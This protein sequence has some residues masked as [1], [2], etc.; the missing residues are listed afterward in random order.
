MNCESSIKKAQP[1]NSNELCGCA[2]NLQ[3]V[4]GKRTTTQW[5]VSSVGRFILPDKATC[6][7]PWQAIDRPHYATFGV[8]VNVS[9]RVQ[10]RDNSCFN[11]FRCVA[12][13]FE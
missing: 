2:F 9:E 12:S 1:W 8:F 5:F 6:P 3:V 7:D 4:R 11:R 10:L 13:R